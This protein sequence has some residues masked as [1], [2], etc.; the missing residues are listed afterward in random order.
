MKKDVAKCRVIRGEDFGLSPAAREST[1]GPRQTR[2]AFRR[3][4][5]AIAESIRYGTFVISARDSSHKF[6]G[7]MLLSSAAMKKTF[8]AN[9]R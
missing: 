9:V 3:R 5:G 7:V 4:S 8:Y 6:T 1:P 2:C